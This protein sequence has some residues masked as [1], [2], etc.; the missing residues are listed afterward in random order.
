MDNISK[1]NIE[2]LLRL[3]DQM[4][5]CYNNRLKI[6]ARKLVVEEMGRRESCYR[7]AF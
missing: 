4:I 3:G 5:D 1:E 2:A 7:M 6:L